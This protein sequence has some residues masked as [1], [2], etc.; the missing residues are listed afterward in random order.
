VVRIGGLVVCEQAPPTAKG[1]VFLTLEDETGLANV[2]LRPQVYQSY[3]LVLQTDQMVV[4]EGVIN[5]QD[6][7]TN[8]MGRKILSL[9]QQ[10][11][12]AGSGTK[13]PHRR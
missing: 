2:I 7:I 4:V 3:R 5:R 10:A 6:G 8:L 12:V 9:H 11:L 13:R 1:H